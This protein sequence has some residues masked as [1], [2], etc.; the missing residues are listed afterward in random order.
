MSYIS[1]M[2]AFLSE[3]VRVSFRRFDLTSSTSSPSSKGVR[4][5]TGWL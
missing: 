2:S 5:G 3:Y 1:S 4:S